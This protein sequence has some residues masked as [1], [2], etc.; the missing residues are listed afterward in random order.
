MVI[1]EIYKNTG[2]TRAEIWDKIHCQRTRDNS[3]EADLFR[4]LI[5]DLSTGG[6]IRKERETDAH[7]NFIEKSTR[8]HSRSNS[9]RTME[10]AFEDTKP[11]ELTE[12][13]TQ[14]VHYVMEDVVAQIGNGDRL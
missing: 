7:G 10:S 6:V 9:S 8:G 11:Y 13:G 4:Y 3:A 2:I 1:R 5:R 14:F 12:L